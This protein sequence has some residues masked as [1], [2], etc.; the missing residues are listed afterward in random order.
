MKGNMGLL[1]RAYLGILHGS[2]P[3]L[4]QVRFLSPPASIYNVLCL[5]QEQA[6]LLELTVTEWSRHLRALFTCGQLKS[7]SDSLL[8]SFMI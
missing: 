4:L 7:Q 1:R 5:E 8:F 3:E 6:T 2:A